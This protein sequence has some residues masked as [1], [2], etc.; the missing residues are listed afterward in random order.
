MN[1]IYQICVEVISS[2]KTIWKTFLINDKYFIC[3]KLDTLSFLTQSHLLVTFHRHRYATVQCANCRHHFHRKVLA[4][5]DNR[6]FSD[7]FLQRNYKSSTFDTSGIVFY[8]VLKAPT[9]SLV[10]FVAKLVDNN[11]PKPIKRS[12]Y[13]R[14]YTCINSS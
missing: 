1:K 12:Q 6:L 9:S 5:D 7:F 3:V 8:Y 4:T 13:I 10:K 11:A 2:W 14:I